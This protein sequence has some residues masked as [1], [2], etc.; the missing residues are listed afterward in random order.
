MALSGL[1]PRASVLP[2]G[3]SV[4]SFGRFN[5]DLDM[6]LELSDVNDQVSLCSQVSQRVTKG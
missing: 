1:F 6:V 2:F 4:N 5:C 3:S